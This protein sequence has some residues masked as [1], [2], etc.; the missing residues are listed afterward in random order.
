[1]HGE[2]IEYRARLHRIIFLKAYFLL[3]VCIL[4]IAT[5]SSIIPKFIYSRIPD[6]I[7]NILQYQYDIIEYLSSV[8]PP[9]IITQLHDNIIKFFLFDVL[10]ILGVILFVLLAFPVWFSNYIT[11]SSSEF[12]I[13]NKRVLIKM[14]FIKRNSFETLLSKVESIGV[15]QSILGRFL[16]FGTIIIT[17]TGGSKEY[18][19]QISNPIKFRKKVQEQ[20]V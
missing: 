5:G 1:M 12:G 13:S 11:Y 14:G 17:G 7:S 10:Q 8:I 19:Y 18:F 16:N 15:E 9:N 6:K 2:Q 4:L 20:I 3:A